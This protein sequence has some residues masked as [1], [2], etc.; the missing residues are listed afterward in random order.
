MFRALT[1]TLLVIC[2]CTN[3]YVSTHTNECMQCIVVMI[4]WSLACTC[5]P[6][7]KWH[8]QEHILFTQTLSLWL[9][10]L[11]FSNTQAWWHTHTYGDVR[12]FIFTPALGA[13]RLTTSSTGRPAHLGP[14]WTTLALLDQT[15]CA[16]IFVHIYAT[17]MVSSFNITVT[18]WFPAWASGQNK[19]RG[20]Q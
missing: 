15:V 14:A 12:H 17:E 18:Q 6:T 11:S 9:V 2:E 16:L 8:I 1:H 19:S 4:T 3:T 13:P 5:G 20:P 7:R 10:S